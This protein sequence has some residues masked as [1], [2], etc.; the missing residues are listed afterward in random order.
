M[1]IAVD[2]QGMGWVQRTQDI[3]FFNGGTGLH[4]VP[5]Q[6]FASFCDLS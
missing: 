3:V 6:I 1:A 2:K 5:A 4:G